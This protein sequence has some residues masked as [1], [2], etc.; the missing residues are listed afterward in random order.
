VNLLQIKQAS[1]FV[2]ICGCHPFFLTVS[3][4]EKRKAS[5]IQ[6]QVNILAPGD[7]C[8]ET[9]FA[10]AAT[11]GIVLS[12]LNN[13]VT[14]RKDTERCCAKCGRFSGEMKSLK[15]SPFPD[16]ECVLATWF[17]Q[18]TAISALISGSLLREKALRIATWL[19]IKD[20]R[21]C[22]CWI[23]GFKQ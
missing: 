12:T 21:A 20:F 16:V 14:N 11:L 5:C 8:K 3:E 2:L 1:S 17:E 10:L 13:T 6:E 23:D 18:A 4:L 19:G 9:H 15:Q 22:N 7:A